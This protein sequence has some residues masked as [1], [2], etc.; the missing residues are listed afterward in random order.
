MLSWICKHKKSL[1]I[2]S[3]SPNFRQNSTQI[4]VRHVMNDLDTSL[5]HHNTDCSNRWGIVP[6]SN[7]NSIHIVF[8]QSQGCRTI[9][10]WFLLKTFSLLT[11]CGSSIIEL[12]LENALVLPALL[13]ETITEGE[14]ASHD[15][16]THY[17]TS[18]NKCNQKWL[19]IKLRT[20]VT[21]I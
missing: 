17:P 1:W 21:S 15:H 12:R 8:W 10:S 7:F 16:M 9:Q 6:W 2:Y 20:I 4:C 11:F 18:Q 5:T 13:P 14:T 19:P 3:W